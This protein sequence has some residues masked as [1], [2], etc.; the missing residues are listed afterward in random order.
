MHILKIGHREGRKREK[1]CG[2]VEHRNIEERKQKKKEK[3]KKRRSRRKL[4]GESG[5]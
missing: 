5:E 1:I 3:K 2:D 4:G